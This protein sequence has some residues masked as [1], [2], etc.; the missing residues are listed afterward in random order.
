MV[1][2]YSGFEFN[3]MIWAKDSIYIGGYQIIMNSKDSIK[4]SINSLTNNSNMDFKIEMGENKIFYANKINS[5]L[6]ISFRKRYL[7][8]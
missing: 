3:T 4:N 6:K 7:G 1:K 8:V 2:D 5:D